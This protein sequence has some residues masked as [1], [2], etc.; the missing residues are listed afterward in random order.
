MRAWRTLPLVML[1]GGVLLPGNLSAAFQGSPECG[2]FG[3][4]VG[5]RSAQ[6]QQILNRNE[7]D[8]FLWKHCNSRYCGREPRGHYSMVY[9]HMPCS[10]SCFKTK[11]ARYLQA[12]GTQ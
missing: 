12:C 6:W 3:T 7:I 10:R 9:E 4:S 1:V 8:R 11:K 2:W 5:A